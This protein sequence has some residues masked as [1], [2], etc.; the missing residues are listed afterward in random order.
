MASI[1]RRKDSK[2]WWA[3]IRAEDGKWRS[4]STGVER[5]RD[6][7][8]KADAL[9]YA[10]SVEKAAEAA[11]RR[12]LHT[13]RATEL[14]SKLVEISTGKP[15]ETY[16]IAG[17]LKYFLTSNKATLA[18]GS[19][20]RYERS[21]DDFIAHL[22]AKAE[23]PLDTLSVKQVEDFRDAELATGK[24]GT[25]V[26]L[27]I[28]VLR[29]ALATAHK[30]GLVKLNA[31][32]AC[33][34][35]V[36]DGQ[37]RKVFTRGEIDALLRA[38]KGLGGTESKE[39]RAAILLG[40][41]TGQRLQDVLRIKWGAFDFEKG[42]I[43]M[44]QQKQRRTE[45]KRT[46]TIPLDSEA[47]SAVLDL[48]AADK[49]GDACA[50]ATLSKLRAGGCN[51]MSARF[52]GLMAKAGIDR[53]EVRSKA[54]DSKGRRTFAKGF[55]SLRHTA[56]S[57]LANAGVEERVAMNLTGHKNKT[58]HQRYTKPQVKALREAQG[59]LRDG[60]ED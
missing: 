32:A 29:A 11:S 31:A 57:A 26:T 27:E 21:I 7:Q 54:K 56:A 60:L 2:V 59:K 42:V 33:K 47:E 6:K 23:R 51:G 5:K 46:I 24:A 25:S 36:N 49:A 12:E 30:R 38:A 28:K 20:D 45:A 22:G 1:Y 58:M 48:P 43:E 17:W 55:H 8:S 19:F 9:D 39:W 15:L 53:V 40:L 50:M 16:T 44:A 35:A 52:A 4:I 41:T 37:T 13:A 10:T 14:I 34:A 3:R 18:K